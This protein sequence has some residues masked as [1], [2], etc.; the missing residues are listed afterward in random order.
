MPDHTLARDVL[1]RTGP[2]AVS[3]A[4]LSGQRAATTCDQAAEQ[5]GDRVAVYLDGGA[6]PWHGEP[7]TIVDFASSSDG[8]VLRKGALSV[9]TIRQ[10]CPSVVDPTSP[11]PKPPSRNRRPKANLA[12]PDASE[13]EPAP[14]WSKDA[15]Y[16]PSTGSG[17]EGSSG[18]EAGGPS[19]SSGPEGG[20]GHDDAYHE[21]T[22]DELGITHTMVDPDQ[23]SLFERDDAPDA[24]PASAR[25]ERSLER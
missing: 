12:Q 14:T 1:R 15:G 13:P 2:M 3:S 6:R 18:H 11:R 17:H 16:G 20:S 5:L 8:I 19:T 22:T 24:E 4:N 23:P 21:P 25:A 9:E 10:T 7:S